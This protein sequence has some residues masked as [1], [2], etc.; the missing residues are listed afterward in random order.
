MQ[1]QPDFG[2]P[3]PLTNWHR[4]FTHIDAAFQYKT[5]QTY[6]FKGEQFYKF[7]DSLFSVLNPS[8]N[9]PILW[10]ILSSIHIFVLKHAHIELHYFGYVLQYDEDV[11]PRSIKEMWLG[12]PPPILDWKDSVWNWFFGSDDSAGC[13][14]T[15]LQLNYAALLLTSYTFFGLYL[16]HVRGHL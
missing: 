14:L 16:Q 15:C 6:F 8:H 2:Y 3:R 10:S 11:Y 9:S 13:T 12:C 5:R 1:M 7:N 4:D